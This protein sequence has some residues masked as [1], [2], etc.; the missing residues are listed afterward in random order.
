MIETAYES[1]KGKVRCHLLHIERAAASF[2]MCVDCRRPLFPFPKNKCCAHAVY[3]CPDCYTPEQIAE[4]AEQRKGRTYY[5]MDN[6]APA[7]G[8]TQELKKGK[9]AMKNV[10]DIQRGSGNY[11]AEGT[12]LL[13]KEIVILTLRI[14][15]RALP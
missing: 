12:R 2:T 8:A 9:N 7:R 13:G 6:D 3:C 11:V 1:V 4:F 10:K 14:A 5:D 15:V